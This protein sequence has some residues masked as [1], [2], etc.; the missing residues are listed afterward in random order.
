VPRTAEEC[1]QRRKRMREFTDYSSRIPK[2]MEELKT[3]TLTEAERERNITRLDYTGVGYG[4]N[5]KSNYPND[6][7]KATQD[8]K[9][10][11]LKRL[12][13]LIAAMG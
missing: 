7:K 9:I 2:L 10:P 3:K 6:L 13:R 1:S 12:E 8:I 5:L 11:G 4:Y